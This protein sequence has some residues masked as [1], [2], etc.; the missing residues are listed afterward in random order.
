MQLD[1]LARAVK[2]LLEPFV[3]E[4][5]DQVIDGG[6]IEGRD[7][8]IVSGGEDHR[9]HSLGADLAHDL[10][11]GLAGHLDIEEHEIR[12]QL[13]DGLDVGRAHVCTPVTL[14]FRMPSSAREETAF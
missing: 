7:R 6:E 8:V 1:H 2:S 4:R 3:V 5:L 9:R 13:A 11:S 14:Y 12:L 10:E